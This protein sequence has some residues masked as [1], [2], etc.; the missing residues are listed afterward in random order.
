MD[1]T[2][3]KME[4]QLLRWHKKID[5]LAAKVQ[6]A[7]VETRFDTLLYIDELKA[8]HAIAQSKFDAFKAAKIPERERYEVEMNRA[9]NELDGAFRNPRPSP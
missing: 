9:W 7:G 2:V 6:M 5:N 1:P 8:L 4:A 3:Q